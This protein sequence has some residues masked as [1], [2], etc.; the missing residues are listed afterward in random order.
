MIENWHR[1]KQIDDITF[2]YLIQNLQKKK[3]GKFFLLPKIHK[4]PANV[5]Q[6]LQKKNPAANRNFII[7]GRPISTQSRTFYRSYFVTTG[8][9]TMYI[10][11]ILSISLEK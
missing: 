6:D 1:S 5:L 4:I 2:S 7:P 8:T 11:N 10:H 3:L 9:K